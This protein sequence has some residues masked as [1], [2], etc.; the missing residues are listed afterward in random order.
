MITL[1]VCFDFCGWKT[2]YR[3]HVQTVYSLFFFRELQ[4]NSAVV[5]NMLILAHRH[6]MLV[7]G[8]RFCCCLSLFICSISLT[9]SNEHWLVVRLNWM[10]KKCTTTKR[11][12]ERLVTTIASIPWKYY[13]KCYCAT[14]NWLYD[15]QLLPDGGT[16]VC[17]ILN[18]IDFICM[19]NWA[20][21]ELIFFF[22][23]KRNTM[24]ALHN[25]RKFAVHCMET[26]W[27]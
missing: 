20:R 12:C 21:I 7:F 23:L 25:R 1:H 6:R 8:M 5:T 2:I 11:K 14:W 24:C 22:Y 18:W 27:L 9:V 3:E 15:A 19:W 26:I 4:T 16:C 10:H 17:S 13:A